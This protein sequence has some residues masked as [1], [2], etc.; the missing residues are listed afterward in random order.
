MSSFY[1]MNMHALPDVTEVALAVGA[2]IRAQLDSPRGNGP[3]HTFVWLSRRIE[4][5]TRMTVGSDTIRQFLNSVSRLG[6]PNAH[7]IN[8]TNTTLEALYDYIVGDYH[9]FH[10]DVHKVFLANRDALHLKRLADEDMATI[11]EVLAPYAIGTQRWL[12]VSGRDMRELSNKL[13]GNHYVLRKSTINSHEF[14]KSELSVKSHVKDLT[15]YL[16]ITHRHQQRSKAFT[17]SHGFI[18]RS[19]RNVYAAMQIEG[20]E[21]LELLVLR[22]EIQRA[23]QFFM[24]FMIGVNSDR[25]VYESSVLVIP[26]KSLSEHRIKEAW[27]NLPSRFSEANQDFS[28]L[29]GNTELGQLVKS[30][31]GEERSRLLPRFGDNE[32]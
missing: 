29:L 6:T 10:P 27:D 5:V 22:E 31:L 12:N 2:I 11:D 25:N 13:V 16:S 21:G 9:R 1:K 19:I 15:T 18:L 17:K 24:G 8:K 4:V 20:H 30:V 7:R 26:A 14:M 3:K 32:D 28:W 23:P